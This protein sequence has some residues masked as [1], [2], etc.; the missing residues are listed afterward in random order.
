MAH[1]VK[2]LVDAIDWWAERNRRGFVTTLDAF[3][4]FG[5]VRCRDSLTQMTQ[6]WSLAEEEYKDTLLVPR[7][8]TTKDDRLIA[9]LM[10]SL[11]YSFYG[12]EPSGKI[13]KLKGK[14]D[15]ESD[16]PPQGA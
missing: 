15:E 9:Q 13:K 11:V 7:E 6:W 8:L 16:L 2:D 10:G 3:K 12:E 4:K 5:I 14:L 1:L